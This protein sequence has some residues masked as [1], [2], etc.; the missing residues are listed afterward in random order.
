M[1]LLIHLIRH[2]ETDANI[3]CIYAG[4]TDD[5]LNANG[6]AQCERALADWVALRPHAVFSSPMKRTLETL[7]TAKSR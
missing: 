2:A 6:R 1:A 7:E 4:R 5:G 3:H